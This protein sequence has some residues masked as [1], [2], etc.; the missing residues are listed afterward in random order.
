MDAGALRSFLI[1]RR[2]NI[3]DLVCT[4][5]AV[6]AL[7]TGFPGARIEALV[8]SYNHDVLAGRPDFDAVHAYS[9]GKHR[10]NESLAAV[11]ARRMRLLWDLRR[12]GFDCAI[13]AAPGLQPRALGYARWVRP[14][15]IV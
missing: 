11:Y 14:K 3:G 15:H 10:E 5:P 4:L 6:S 1:I 12:Q 8:N 7:R 2:D 13:L 9:K